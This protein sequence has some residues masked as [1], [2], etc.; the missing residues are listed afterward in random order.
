MSVV[1][2]YVTKHYTNISWLLLT[3]E[4]DTTIL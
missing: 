4:T 3:F 2:Y 1:E